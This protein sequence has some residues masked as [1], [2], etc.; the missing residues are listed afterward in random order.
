MASNVSPFLGRKRYHK[1][2]GDATSSLLTEEQNSLWGSLKAGLVEAGSILELIPCPVALWSRDR[3]LCV[4][5]DSTRQLLGFCEHDF[6]KDPSLWTDRIPPRDRAAFLTEWTK[7]QRGEK[8][9]SCSYR[10]LP[11]HRATEIRLREVSVSYPI[12]G[13]AAGVWSLYN[14]DPTAEDELGGVQQVRELVRGLTHEIGNSL[15]AISGEVDLLRLSGVLA[16]ENSSAVTNGVK[17]IRKLAHEIEEYLA[18]PPLELRS[19]DPVTVLKEVIQ[20]RQ[21][22]L[23]AQDIRI[24]VGLRQSLPRVPLDEQ[25]RSALERVVD[26]SC[27]LLPQGGELKI[28]A[29]LQQIGEV[30]YIELNLVTASPTSITVDEKD[31]FRPFLKLNGCRVGLSMA[32]ARQVLRRHFGKIIFR[33][34]RCDQGVFSILIKVPSDSSKR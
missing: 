31:V 25:F 8:R 15:Q 21:S 14:E 18:P 28:E 9:I 12:R 17:Q 4:F 30:D 26:F 22:E 6:R 34:E 32:M 2:L 13:D 24:A 3:R 20:S 29:G 11:N 7:L 5:N 33:K 16:P 27:A 1:P 23:V 19:E 10:F